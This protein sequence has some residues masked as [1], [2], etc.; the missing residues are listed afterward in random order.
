M[1]PGQP[2]SMDARTLSIVDKL[3]CRDNLEDGGGSFA[4]TSASPLVH[5][6]E[7]QQQQKVSNNNKNQ[8]NKGL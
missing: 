7:Q 5:A 3:H 1:D 6:G 8:T 4:S 2:N